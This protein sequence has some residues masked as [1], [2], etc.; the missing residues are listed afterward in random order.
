MVHLKSMYYTLDVKFLEYSKNLSYKLLPLILLV[1][2]QVR[3]YGETRK[4]P[5]T[6]IIFL[7]LLVFIFI[8][9][10]ILHENASRIFFVPKSINKYAPNARIV[11]FLFQI[12]YFSPK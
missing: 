1:I 12:R 2:F 5:R 3:F 10:N 11:K 4:D 7:H 9:M 6:C 8:L